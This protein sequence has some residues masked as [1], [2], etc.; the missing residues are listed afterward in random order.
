MSRARSN[1]LFTVAYVAAGLL[2]VLVVGYLSYRQRFFHL[3]EP[4][5]PY[6]LVGLIGALIYAAV[7]KQH[8]WLAILLIALLYMADLALKPPLT[9][10]LLLPAASHALPVGF[11]MFAAAVVLKSLA[12]IRRRNLILTLLVALAGIILTAMLVGLGYTLSTILFIARTREMP[13][14]LHPYYLRAGVLL[15]LKLG[16]AMGL[17]FKLVDLIGSRSKHGPHYDRPRA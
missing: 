15:G 16:A 4:M 17:G 7:Q 1:G 12:R 13:A 3:P 5:V 11:S 2:A 9:V 6:L 8:A 10:R 14:T